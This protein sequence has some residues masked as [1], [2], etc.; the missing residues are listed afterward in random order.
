[1][2]MDG[3]CLGIQAGDK[4]PLLEG[5]DMVLVFDDDDLVGPDGIR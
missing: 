5:L 3:F 2:P 1:M 4:F